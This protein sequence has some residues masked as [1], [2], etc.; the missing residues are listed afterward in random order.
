MRRLTHIITIAGTLTTL[1]LAER[2]RRHHF[3]RP[4]EVWWTEGEPRLSR[5]LDPTFQNYMANREP[6]DSF[7]HNSQRPHDDPE[8]VWVGRF[9]D[10]TDRERAQEGSPQYFDLCSWPHRPGRRLELPWTLGD[11]PYDTVARTIA[12]RGRVIDPGLLREPGGMATEHIPTSRPLPGAWVSGG[13][14]PL[15]HA[16]VQVVRRDNRDPHIICVRQVEPSLRTTLLSI[17]DLDG[18]FLLTNGYMNGIQLSTREAISSFR[19]IDTH[20]PSAGQTRRPGRRV[21]VDL[22]LSLEVASDLK[23]ADLAAL[24]IDD[25]GWP[26]TGDSAGPITPTVNGAPMADVVEL[27]YN[28][29]SALSGGGNV[30]EMEA[31]ARDYNRKDLIEFHFSLDLAGLIAQGVEH[32]DLV[33]ALA[34]K[35]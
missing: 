16:C 2:R 22:K 13:E 6:V 7:C 28:T 27:C 34:G 35:G 10:R 25:K 11:S 24:L 4:G 14:C 29:D 17:A 12:E 15:S 20:P 18:Y 32:I 31:G 5:V 21:D 8:L 19:F 26:L 9:C 3:W 23:D 1:A 33:Y 30:C